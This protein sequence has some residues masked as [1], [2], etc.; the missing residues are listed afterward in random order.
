MNKQIQKSQ[1]S[2]GLLMMFVIAMPALLFSS[3]KKKKVTPSVATETYYT[4]TF[5]GKGGSEVKTITG[6][7]YGSTITLPASPTKAGSTFG[8]WYTDKEATTSLFSAT[9]PI[10]ADLTLYAKWNAVASGSFS[11]SSASFTNGGSIPPRHAYALEKQPDRLNISPQLSWVNAPEGTN[12]FLI[13]MSDLDFTSYPHWTVFNIPADKFS[14]AENE[15]SSIYISDIEYSYTGPHPWEGDTHTYQIT[16]FA[17][18]KAAN[19]FNATNNPPLLKDQ[20]VEELKNDILASASIKGTFT[21][22]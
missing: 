16:I 5:D 11:L 10:T 8:G 17:L 15:M 9:T 19:Y 22:K 12:S 13:I 14:L 4:V 21:S 3:C 7:K 20:A 18:K 1:I 6:V 2:I